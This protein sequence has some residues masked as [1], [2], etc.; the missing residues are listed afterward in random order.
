MKEFYN[1]GKGVYEMKNIFRNTTKHKIVAGVLLVALLVNTLLPSILN[2]KAEVVNAAETETEIET[3]SWTTCDYP[4]WWHDPSGSGTTMEYDTHISG[5]DCVALTVNKNKIEVCYKR[6]DDTVDISDMDYLEFDLYVSATDIFTAAGDAKLELTSS[7]KS[8]QQEID[9]SMKNLSLTVGWNHVKLPLANFRAVNG[10]LGVACDKTAINY[11]RIFSAGHSAA[12]EMTMKL[13]NIEFTKADGTDSF[14]WSDCDNPGLWFN[15]I[16]S[17][18]LTYDTHVSGKDCVIRSVNGTEI[19]L[20]YRSA[21]NLV[22][23][24]EMEYLEFDLYVSDADIFSAAGDTK[25]EL[26]STNWADNGEINYDMKNISLESGWNHVKLALA[27]FKAYNPGSENGVDCDKESINFLRLYAV[28]HSSAKD[29]TVKMDN[30]VFTKEVLVEEQVQPDE[31]MWDNCDNPGKWYD[32]DNVNDLFYD[33]HESGKASEKDCVGIAESGT[34]IELRYLNTANPVDIT[35]MDYLEFDLFISSKDIF[36]AAA[37]AKLEL[38]SSGKSDQQEIDYDLKKLSLKAGWNHV[39]LPLANFRAVNGSEGVACNKAAINYLRIFNTGHSQARTMTIK[40]DNV[41]FTK[42]NSEETS[43]W[44]DCDYPGRWY[45][46]ATG[47]NLTYGTHVSGEDCVVW[48]ATKNKVEV[49]YTRAEHTVNI[50]GMDYLEFD[51]YLSST[52]IIYNATDAKLELTSSGGPDNQELNYSL[53]NLDLTDGWNHVKLPLA[54]FGVTGGAC[55]KTAMNYIRI[56]CIGFQEA[57]DM[58]IMF[59][60]LMFTKEPPK[61]TVKPYEPEKPGVAE[62][63]GNDAFVWTNCDYAGT[64]SDVSNGATLLYDTRNSGRDCVTHSVSANSISVAY[65]C[66]GCPID[67]SNMAYLEFDLYVSEADIFST[68]GDTKL[69]LTSSGTHDQQEINYNLK[70]LSLTKGWNHVQLPLADFS[71][72]DGSEGVTCDK[73]AINYMR[74]FSAGH[75]ETRD[76]TIK[77]DNFVF[78]GEGDSADTIQWA[79]CDDAGT[80]LNPSTSATAS[81]SNRF[82]IGD[83]VMNA[84]NATDIALV[85]RNMYRPVDIT[86]YQ[87]MEFDICVSA[88]DLFATAGDAQLELTSCD[89]WDYKEINYSLKDLSLVEGW[90]H[91]VLPLDGFNDLT[92]D[93]IEACNRE[94]ISLMRIYSAGYSENQ[95]MTI[96]LDNV[97]FTKGEPRDTTKGYITGCDSITGWATNDG[98]TM[99]VDLADKKQGKGSMSFSGNSLKNLE[100]VYTFDAMDLSDAKSLEFYLYVSDPAF[101]QNVEDVNHIQV[102]LSSAGA[103]DNE[104]ISW[105]ADYIRG[106][107]L[108]AGWNLVQLPFSRGNASG[109]KIDFTK[110]NYFRMYA[111][112]AEDGDYTFKIDGLKGADVA[113]NSERDTTSGYITGCDSTV[114]WTANDGVGVKL[115]SIDKKQGKGSVAFT[116]KNKKNFEMI[117]TLDAMNVTGA[118]H[119]EFYLYVS[120]PALIQKV[121]DANNLQVEISSTGGPDNGE[122]HWNANY[123]KGLDL[124]TGWNKVRLPIVEGTTS[125]DRFDF[126]KLSYFRIYAVFEENS[127]YT[128]KI[129]GLRMTKTVGKA[130]DSPVLS[131]DFDKVGIWKFNAPVSVDTKTMMQGTGSVK[132]DAKDMKNITAFANFQPVDVSS[133]NAIQFYLWVSDVSQLESASDMQLEITSGGEPDKQEIHWNKEQLLDCIYQDGWNLVT[134][135]FKDAE[136]TG[137]KIN[138]GGINYIRLY[139]VSENAMDLVCRFDDMDVLKINDFSAYEKLA[140]SEQKPQNN[141]LILSNGDSLRGWSTNEK[142]TLSLDKENKVDGKASI[143]LDAKEMVLL[144]YVCA[145]Y[146]LEFANCL[147]FDLYIDSLKYFNT[148][149]YQVE[150]S[151]NTD[152]D[153]AEINW[154]KNIFMSMDLKQGWNHIVL[155]F[156]DAQESKALGNAFD[157]SSVNYFRFYMTGVEATTVR[158]DNLK[159][160]YREIDETDDELVIPVIEK[161][162]AKTDVTGNEKTVTDNT[163]LKVA[164]VSAFV[165]LLTAIAVLIVL[166]KQKKDQNL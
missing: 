151:S 10:S 57:T 26:T 134:L 112:F 164:C 49:V 23:I 19:A 111:V 93:G 13:D 1:H 154:T 67:I 68:A 28:G 39:Q 121:T 4:G 98:V 125:G 104:E 29:M 12:R 120:D 160:T 16:D 116:G 14:V 37:D 97:T 86:E 35:D 46:P 42:E 22:D 69:E 161:N 91:V 44:T 32:P 95:N 64:W 40:V 113:E 48:N 8:D 51:M 3:L 2:T 27:D 138:Y 50:T 6:Y 109:D 122:I 139:I 65:K 133:A 7:G 77:L 118:E 148:E 63:E 61:P 106:L 52:D 130:A 153:D 24:S 25:L 5:E 165:I 78:V 31:L 108:Q 9:Y 89:L 115:D 15:P 124:K 60:N 94:K 75:S 135:A 88:A 137:G 18:T 62:I 36:T 92:G 145:P 41:E 59:D 84:V 126:S 127:N 136:A 79:S 71:V 140:N 43:L 85:Y 100:M 162:D 66:A 80:W 56:Y 38:T 163:V 159:A 45:D 72:A 21:E 150:L 83:C 141:E 96:M 99:Q 20:C 158:I 90:N 101:V 58:T 110:I 81:A 129:D 147:E 152:A 146:N 47:K 144:Q 74:I 82:G 11:M 166:I 87:Y 102:E 105:N 131:F 33:V 155:Q 142:S 123:I 34:G 17:T 128:F 117:Y 149:D 76:M 132:V 114:G 54:D 53:R 103:P 157:A 119:L 143:K 107:D 70:K 55:D 30:V 156:D 73:T